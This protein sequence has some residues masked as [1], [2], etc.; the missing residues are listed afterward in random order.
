MAEV[1]NIRLRLR[2]DPPHKGEGKNVQGKRKIT[3]YTP[4]RI[5]G[6]DDPPSPAVGV[7]CHSRLE[8]CATWKREHIPYRGRP[9]PRPG[10][11]E[12][13]PACR[14]GHTGGQTCQDRLSHMLQ[15]GVTAQEV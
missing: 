14:R 4:R 6:P 7:R 1:G 13:P 9:I 8:S 3:S 10:K 5:R 12:K 15:L 11:A 2:V